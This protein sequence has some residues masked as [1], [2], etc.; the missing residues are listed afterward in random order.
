MLNSVPPLGHPLQ[1]NERPM[2]PPLRR[3]A[4]SYFFEGSPVGCVLI[5]EWQA[6][7][8]SSARWGTILP[9]KA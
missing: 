1:M 2:S 3:G 7:P 4:G 6:R 5:Q 9:G 8:T